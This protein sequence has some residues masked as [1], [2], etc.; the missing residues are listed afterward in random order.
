MT[1]LLFV[2]VLLVY[3][4][5]VSALEN[6]L[7]LRPPM[8]WKS[9]ERFRCN[10]D[11]DKSPDECISEKLYKRMADELVAQGYRD[12]GYVFVSIDDCWSMPER[13]QGNRLVADT[14]RFPSGIKALAKYMHDRGLKLGIYADAGASTC[15]G[16]PGSMQYVS[17]DAQTF[18][19]WDIDMLKFDGCNV[20]DPKTAGLIYIAM[21]DALN[22]TGRDILYSCEWPLYQLEFKLEV[23][24][25]TVAA[26]C[27]T[28]R[29]YYDVQDKFE[30]VQN[31]L[32]FYVRYQ[33]DLTPHQRPGAFFDPDALVIGNFGLSHD[34]SQTQMAL[35]AIWGSPLFMS[36]DLTEVEP[37]FKAILQNEAV[38]A[39]NQDPEG[40][41]GVQIAK[42]GGVRVLRRRVLP[43]IKDSYSLG[44]AFVYTN[45]GGS[46][47][48][49]SVSAQDCDLKD[50]RGYEVVDLFSNA[51]LGLLHPNDTMSITINPSG[52]RLFKA[53]IVG[54]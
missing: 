43:K 28:F 35:W 20:P 49:L 45:Q 4:T 9:W 8:G 6:G 46:P 34:E 5:P 25:E 24:F 22:K 53:T 26:T 29:N 37:G 1:P 38:I 10:I 47:K 16:Y 18:A 19:D 48:T 33:D 31:V 14:K 50:T 54:S 21:T 13:D 7:A 11:C 12:L 15:R 27:N 41:M 52:V 42:L 30:S 39:L 40:L 23:N 51:T 44:L 36:N 32:D 2:A 3:H 17:T